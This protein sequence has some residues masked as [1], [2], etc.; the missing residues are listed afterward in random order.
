[1][2][3]LST[4][5]PRRKLAINDCARCSTA[6]GRSLASRLSTSSPRSIVASAAA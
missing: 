1:M 3:T 4:N 2:V 5:L 6:Y